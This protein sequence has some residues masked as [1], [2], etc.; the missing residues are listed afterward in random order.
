MSL[1]AKQGVSKKQTETDNFLKNLRTDPDLAEN[2]HL[3]TK[4][5]PIPTDVKNSI[6][7]GSTRQHTLHKFSA[8]QFWMT[9]F[10]V[11]A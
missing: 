1:R 11:R 3:S 7:L 10:F 9:L 6:P 2:R 8:L 5:M 4:P